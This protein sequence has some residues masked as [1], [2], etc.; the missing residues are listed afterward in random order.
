M[1]K[2]VEGIPTL[3]HIAVF[4]FFAGLVEFLV[5]IHFGLACVMLVVVVISGGLYSVIT[6]LPAM[7]RNCPYRTPLSGICWRFL[8]AFSF[9]RFCYSCGEG[10][11][12]TGNIA[13]GQ[14]LQA[15]EYSVTRFQ[16]DFRALKWTVEVLTEDNDFEAFVEGLR[17]YLSDGTSPAIRY[18]IL[19]TDTQLVHR[20]SRLLGTCQS[21]TLPTDARRRRA[22]TAMGALKALVKVLDS[23]EWSRKWTSLA[24]FDPILGQTLRQLQLDEEHTISSNAGLVITCIADKLRR[25]VGTITR[26]RDLWN[27][28]GKPSALTWSSTDSALSALNSLGH[29]DG[30]IEMIPDLM[31][32]M[33]SL[34][35]VADQALL[36]CIGMS[37]FERSSI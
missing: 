12:I 28:N 32:S 15:T 27:L 14:E 6:V 26:R 21:T 8:R 13:Q 10:K 16:R 36:L 20:I 1:S 22:L 3:L 23:V 17:V 9:L 4:L 5:P 11:P 25:D 33:P 30:V 34:C 24:S 35:D 19:D 7:R 2:V 29:L 37:G 31:L 18:L